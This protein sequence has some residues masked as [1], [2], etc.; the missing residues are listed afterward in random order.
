[1]ES[2]PTPKRRRAASQRT[3]RWSRHSANSMR[4]LNVVCFGLVGALL[5]IPGRALAQIPASLNLADMTWVEV[6][7]A[8][9]DGF[10]TVIVPS[11]GLEQNGPHMAIGKHDWI[12]DEAARRIAAGVGH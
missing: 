2:L 4:I 6:R 5:L 3:K 12:M 9:G 1:M 8:I 7:A 10:T 11:G